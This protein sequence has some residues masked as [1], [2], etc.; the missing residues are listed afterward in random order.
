MTDTNKINLM[1]NVEDNSANIF[2]SKPVELVLAGETYTLVYNLNAFCEMET[3]YESVDAVIQML[4]G[5]PAPDLNK[6]TYCDAPCMATDIKI[7]GRPLTEYMQRLSNTPKA[8][9]KDTL[10]LLW[11]GVLHDHTKFNADGEVEGYTI[12]KAKLGQ[13][14]T[15]TNIREVNQKIVSAILRDLLPALVNA[16]KERGAEKNEEMQESME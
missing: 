5:T 13:Y 10:N 4:M 15:L 12:S 3:M 16:N 14:V 2:K 1:P 6:V 8:K 11:L 7:D 9:Y